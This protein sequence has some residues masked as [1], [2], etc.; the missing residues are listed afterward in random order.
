[1][2]ITENMERELQ[3]SLSFPDLRTLF[4]ILSFLSFC[5]PQL[6][7]QVTPLHYSQWIVVLKISFPVILLDEALK[8]ISRHHLEGTACLREHVSL[9]MSG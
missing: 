5:V 1:M 3:C 2:V 6:I 9:F 4:L 8:C 7:F